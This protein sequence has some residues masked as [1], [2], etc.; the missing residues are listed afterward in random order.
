MN[1]SLALF[2]IG[3]VFGGAAGFVGAAANGITLDGHDHGS[4]GN[5][6]HAAMDHGGMKHDELLLLGTANAPVVG[7]SITEDAMSGW[8]LEIQ[9]ENFRFA[10]ENASSVH[11]AGEGHAH[12]YV[13]GKK[14]ARHYSNWFH[15]AH[16]PKGDNTIKVSLNAND[17]RQLAVG[18][19]A[20]EASTIIEV[21]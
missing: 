13:N 2:A 12:I 4:H 15:I 5:S 3:L 20:L 1:R 11:V 21:N 9:T 16:L 7:I 19:N 18:N 14:V 6:S 8:N 10:P 17:H